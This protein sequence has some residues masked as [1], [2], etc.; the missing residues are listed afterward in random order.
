MSKD[1]C[2]LYE[3]TTTQVTGACANTHYCYSGFCKIKCDCLKQGDTHSFRCDASTNYKCVPLLCERALTQT[4]TERKLNKIEFDN[5]TQGELNQNTTYTSELNFIPGRHDQIQIL[6]PA[7]N[8]NPSGG[9]YFPDEYKLACQSYFPDGFNYTRYDNGQIY[10]NYVDDYQK[11]IKVFGA[12]QNVTT[13]YN[14]LA[15]PT[16]TLKTITDYSTGK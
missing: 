6:Y 12:T 2:K 4:I 5:T 13:F 15:T 14:N 11:S 9:K 3:G 8:V 10:K 7:N 16:T 1:T